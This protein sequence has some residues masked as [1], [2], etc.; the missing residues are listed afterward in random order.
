M[1]FLQR[2]RKS[3]ER[4]L[5]QPDLAL[6]RSSNAGNVDDW[7]SLSHINFVTCIEKR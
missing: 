3:F 5:K 7:D 2:F 4:F 6:T 1:T